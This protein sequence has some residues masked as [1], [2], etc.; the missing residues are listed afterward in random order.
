MQEAIELMDKQGRGVVIWTQ[1]SITSK[2]LF[3][4]PHKYPMGHAVAQLV[5]TLHYKPEGRRFDSRRYHWNFS[6]T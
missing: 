1:M 2:S 3:K 4:N 6:L 5:E